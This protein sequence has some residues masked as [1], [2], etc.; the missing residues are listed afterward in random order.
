M[1]DRYRL[2]DALLRA[3]TLARAGPARS[4][5]DQRPI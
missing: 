4:Q 5:H 1:A 2:P 3:G